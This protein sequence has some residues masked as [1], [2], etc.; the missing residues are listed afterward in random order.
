VGIPTF[1][2]LSDLLVEPS[3]VLPQ[4]TTELVD[5]DDAQSFVQKLQLSVSKG[6]P[7]AVPVPALRTEEHELVGIPLLRNMT[8]RF[9]TILRQVD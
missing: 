7:H 9:C 1:E 2:I 8:V 4:R 6:L 3:M 5:G